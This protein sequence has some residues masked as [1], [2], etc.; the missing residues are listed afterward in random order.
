VKYT[1]INKETVRSRTKT[2]E[3]AVI[4][5]IYVSENQDTHCYKPGVTQRVYT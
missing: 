4:I 1:I 3:L 5:R 2:T